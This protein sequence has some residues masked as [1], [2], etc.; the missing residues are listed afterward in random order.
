MSNERSNKT[1]ARELES[2]EMSLRKAIHVEAVPGTNGLEIKVED[3]V[4][5]W[6]QQNF[7]SQRSNKAPS[8]NGYPPYSKVLLSEEV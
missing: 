6:L 5:R 7:G 4:W 1:I 8:A 2:I 3:W